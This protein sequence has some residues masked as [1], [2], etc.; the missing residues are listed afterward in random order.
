M[1]YQEIYVKLGLAV[2]TLIA[3]Y[4]IVARHDGKDNNDN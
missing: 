4:Y 2:V 1:D 3:F